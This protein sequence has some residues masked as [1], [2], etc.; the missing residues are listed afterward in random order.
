MDILRVA[1]RDAAELQ[2]AMMIYRYVPSS[3]S[4][5]CATAGGTSHPFASTVLPRVVQ[6]QTPPRRA[7]CKR[8]ETHAILVAGTG[9]EPVTFRL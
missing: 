3:P 2:S 7:A 6:T 5:N 9:F 1:L 4:P 8:L